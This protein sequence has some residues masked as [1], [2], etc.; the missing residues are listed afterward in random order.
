MEHRPARARL[1]PMDI[2][3][4]LTDVASGKKDEIKDGIDSGA[5]A[6]RSKAG[7]KGEMVDKAAEGLKS[8]VDKLPD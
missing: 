8:A 2:A 5:D 3:K 1:P 6:V 4:K 7:D